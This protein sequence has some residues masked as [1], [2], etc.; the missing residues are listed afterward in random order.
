MLRARTLAICLLTSLLAGC[1]SI[2]GL[3]GLDKLFAP[4]GAATVSP[5]AAPTPAPGERPPPS[6]TGASDGQSR[7]VSGSW[8]AYRMDH[9]TNPPSSRT[10]TVTLREDGTFE[11]RSGSSYQGGDLTRMSTM[12]EGKGTYTLKGDALVLKFEDASELAGGVSGEN[13]TLD[14]KTYYPC[15]GWGC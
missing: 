7:V 11:M 4:G 10:S 14:G 12:G 2:E 1:P 9:S 8:K 13:L 5:V 3:G 15:T 6:G